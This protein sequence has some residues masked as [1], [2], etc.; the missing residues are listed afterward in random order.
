MPE[1]RARARTFPTGEIDGLIRHHQSAQ[2][3]RSAGK[4]VDR[5]HDFDPQTHRRGRPDADRKAITF[6][7]W[8]QT[9]S[10]SGSD[11]PEPVR[12]IWQWLRRPVVSKS[13]LVERLILSRP[14][15]E[16]G[17]RL[18]FLP[19]DMRDKVDPY[20]RPLYDALY[21]VLSPERV[22]KHLETGVIEVAP[23]AFMRGRTLRQ[24][25]CDPR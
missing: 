4:L 13:G 22:E 3:G 6:A 25:V 7:R 21:D 5:R 11:Q 16:A 9:I 17:E 20:L 14:A 18:G 23:F 10:F 12:R 8:I 24:R 2:E 15:V 19:G 1:S